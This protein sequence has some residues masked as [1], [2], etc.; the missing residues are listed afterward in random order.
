VPSEDFPKLNET[1]DLN[2]VEE[3][4]Q[5]CEVW[6]AWMK[7]P[8][9]VVGC[10]SWCVYVYLSGR[11]E[12]YMA[13]ALVWPFCLLDCETFHIVLSMLPNADMVSPLTAL[14]SPLR[15]PMRCSY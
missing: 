1:A 7:A 4:F 10:F 11:D 12:N 3:G 5:S 6:F 14:E 2:A 13:T 9:V 8:T 15:F